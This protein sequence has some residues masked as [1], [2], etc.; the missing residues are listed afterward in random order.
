MATI[1]KSNLEFL[2]TLD[3]N[4]NRE[5]FTEN[6]TKYQLEHE[7][8]IAF[9]DD[10]LEKMNQHD[11]IETLNGKKSLFRIYRDIRF[12]KNKTPY[13]TCWSGSFKRATANLRGGYYFHIEPENSFLGGGFWNPNPAD[14]KRIRDEI[15][16]NDTELRSITSTKDFIDTFGVL[17][18]D[19]VKTA[20][21]GF[22]K[23]HPAIDLL[24]YKQFTV[25]KSFTDKEVLSTDFSAQASETFQK[26]RPF[27]NYMSDVLTTDI[28]GISLVE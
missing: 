12:S 20:P 9:A 11:H 3:K 26:M 24:R 19:K 25:G 6:K 4:N 5:W 7:N 28:N 14:L 8:V 21:K 16:A 13:K 23:D 27:L 18:G 1:T 2:K 15:A 17:K 22:A 10:L